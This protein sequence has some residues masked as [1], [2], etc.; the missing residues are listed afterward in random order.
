MV[1]GVTRIVGVGVGVGVGVV[2]CV[3]WCGVVWC[4]VAS[5][6]VTWGDGVVLCGVVAVVSIL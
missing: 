5:V 6:V 4:S 3:V 1:C 2:L